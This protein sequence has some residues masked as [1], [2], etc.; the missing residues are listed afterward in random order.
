MHPSGPACL[1]RPDQIEGR[2]GETLL[3]L[4]AAEPSLLASRPGQTLIGDKH[5]PAGGFEA[6]LFKLLR[7]VIESVNE[8]FKNQLDLE[9]HRGR[10]PSGVIVRVLKTASSR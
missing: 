9:H 5:Y 7:Q 6:Q 10:T 4:F 3:D 2:R 1:L 8:S